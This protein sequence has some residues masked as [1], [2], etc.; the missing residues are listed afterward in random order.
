LAQI[1]EVQSMVTWTPCVSVCGEAAYRGREH[2][3]EQSH[4]P[5]DL[6]IE[7]RNRKSGIHTI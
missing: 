7:K 4:S 5:Y 3:S 6:E 1:L 2:L